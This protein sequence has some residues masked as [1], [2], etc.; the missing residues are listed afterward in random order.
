MDNG[1]PSDTDKGPSQPPKHSRQRNNLSTDS[2]PKKPRKQRAKPAPPARESTPTTVDHG[3]FHNLLNRLL[4]GGLPDDPC[5]SSARI[6]NVRDQPQSEAAAPRY[7]THAPPYP[8]APPTQQ[9]YVY[10]MNGNPYQSASPQ[11][12]PQQA[13]AH[14]GHSSQVGPGIPGHAQYPYTVTHPAYGYSAYSPYASMVMYNPAGPSHTPHG[15]HPDQPSAEP[16]PPP[17]ST[18]TTG[19]RKRKYTIQPSSAPYNSI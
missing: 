9:P 17:S 10:A 13:S 11:Y 12:H 5:L 4:E 8:A 18:P 1:N 14:N 2:Q 3:A 6:S 19:K 15:G 7:S 16:S